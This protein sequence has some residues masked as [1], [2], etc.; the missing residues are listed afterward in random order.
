MVPSR[1]QAS[2]VSFTPPDTQLHC[3]SVSHLA[4]CHLLRVYIIPSYNDMQPHCYK[5]MY[6]LPH[7]I[8]FSNL[9]SDLLQFKSYKHSK[10]SDQFSGFQRLYKQIDYDAKE[11]LIRLERLDLPSK[12]VKCCHNQSL[13]MKLVYKVCMPFQWHPLE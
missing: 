4:A 2:R 12:L 3:T 9:V 1:M 8:S 11:L 10:F 5:L 6:V 13:H 7:C